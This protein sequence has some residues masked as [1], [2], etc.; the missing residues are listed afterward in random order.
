MAIDKPAGWML[1]PMT[2]QKTDQAVS[3]IL[4]NF[5]NGDQAS[6]STGIFKGLPTGGV[7]GITYSTDYTFL[8]SA[9]TAQ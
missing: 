8:S 9:P 3:N 5:Q 4:G 7:T 1:V 6:L 2:W